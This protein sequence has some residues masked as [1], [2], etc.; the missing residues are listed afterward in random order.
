VVA[1]GFVEC[2]QAAVVAAGFVECGQAA[3]AGGDQ[4]NCA[5][6]LTPVDKNESRI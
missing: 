3:V 1:A 2:G 4:R 6:A 5:G